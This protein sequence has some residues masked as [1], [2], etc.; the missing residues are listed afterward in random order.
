MLANDVYPDRLD[1]A[2][3]AASKFADAL[4]TAFNIGLVA[5]AGSAAV[6]V[7]PGTDRRALQFGIRRLAGGT[8]GAEGTAIGEAI[9]TSFRAVKTLDPEAANHPPPARIVLLSDGANNSGRDPLAA[10][11]DAA[12]ANV[13]VH[14]IAF[15]T[16]SGQFGVGGRPIH[17]PVDSETLRAVAEQTQ[18]SYHQAV[19]SAAHRLQEHR[20]IRGLS[21][22]ATGHLGV[23]SS[24]WAC[25]W[26]FWQP[27]GRWCGLP[28]CPDSTPG[29]AR[30]A[31]GAV[32]LG[33]QWPK[34]SAHAASRRP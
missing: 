13:P 27:P 34:G 29:Y 12:K 25:C 15:G 6:L 32:G 30:A 17:A 23:G 28:A 11:G 19:T 22:G 8:I 18:G 7:P 26:R 2:K 1:A 14:A 9:N 31:R 4:P 33:Q 3:A 24:G 16:P 21:H 10:A 20:L 5:F